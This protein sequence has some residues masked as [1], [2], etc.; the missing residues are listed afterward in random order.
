MPRR[1]CVTQ[2]VLFFSTCG[3]ADAA[4][5]VNTRHTGVVAGM[6]V[7]AAVGDAGPLL[8][9]CSAIAFD[10]SVSVGVG[11]TEHASSDLAAR[12]F[13]A[14]TAALAPGFARTARS[15]W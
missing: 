1:S 12:A 2:L 7:S 10:G 5:Q 15:G 9:G 8:D 6:T 4:G 14:T 13:E 11:I 3:I